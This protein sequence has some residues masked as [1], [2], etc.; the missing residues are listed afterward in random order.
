[1]S[2]GRKRGLRWGA[3]FA[4]KT[5]ALSFPYENRLKSERHHVPP[6][7]FLQNP[8]E[9]CELFAVVRDPLARAISEFR[10]PWKGLCAP[11]RSEK[12]R[13]KRLGATSSDLNDWLLSKHRKGAMEP[14]FKNCHF[15]PQAT[16]LLDANDQL[17]LP[18][19]RVLV[20]E[21][22]EEEFARMC[23]EL[24]LPFGGLPH[25]NS[26]EMPRFAINDLT[27][28]VKTMLGDVYARDIEL[29]ARIIS[30]NLGKIERQEKI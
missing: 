27:Q 19:N 4:G 7:F 2:W 15:L 17:L 20:F 6:C 5:G 26:S 10:C 3:F 23:Q 12:A 25:E 9:L 30:E 22:L 8:Y 14:P 21:R 28:E 24:H 11:A 18:S 29:H 16:Y 1:M 13:S